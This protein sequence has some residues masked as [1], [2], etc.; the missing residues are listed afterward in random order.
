MMDHGGHLL[1]TS[2]S[3]ICFN[4]LSPRDGRWFGKCPWSDGEVICFKHLL[5]TSASNICF[6]HLL[7]TSVLTN[8]L[9]EM[10]GGLVDVRGA[11]EQ[12]LSFPWRVI[13]FDFSE[14]FP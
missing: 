14:T 1:Q 6:K 11:M 13:L 12:L 5:Q 8:Y 2:A 9:H 10:V 4:K 7:Q 3:N